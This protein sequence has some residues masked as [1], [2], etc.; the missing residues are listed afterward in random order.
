MK[1]AGKVIGAPLKAIGLIPKMPSV[2]KAAGPVTRDDARD[3]ALREDELRRRRGGA[4]DQLT[5]IRGA[6]AGRA[7]SGAATLG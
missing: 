3:A 6:E 1:A 7:A 4:A 2:P 5:G